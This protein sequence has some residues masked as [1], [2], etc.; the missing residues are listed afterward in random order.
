M[1]FDVINVDRSLSENYMSVSRKS[2]ECLT[3]F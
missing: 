3:E 1:K 2:G